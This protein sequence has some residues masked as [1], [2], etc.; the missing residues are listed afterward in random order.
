MWVDSIR[1]GDRE[2]LR[3]LAT[4]CQAA[5]EGNLANV[6][7][8]D[9]GELVQRLY[10]PLPPAWTWKKQDSRL[11][12]IQ[13]TTYGSEYVYQVDGW[14]NPVPAFGGLA[15]GYYFGVGNAAF[16][17]SPNDVDLCFGHSMGGA[18]AT[19]A[20]E[21]FRRS[22]RPG[23]FAASFGSPRVWADGNSAIEAHD[24]HVFFPLDPVPLQPYDGFGGHNWKLGNDNYMALAAGLELVVPQGASYIGAITAILYTYGASWHAIDNY[25]RYFG[26]TGPLPLVNGFEGVEGMPQFFE[27]QIKGL[28]REQACDNSFHVIPPTD[29]ADPEQ[30]ADDM[31]AFWRRVVCPRL[32]L[33]YQVLSYQT[34]RIASMIWKDEANHNLGSLFRYNGT[35]RYGG[36]NTDWGRRADD[37]MPS[38]IAIGFAK[39]AG[40]YFYPDLLNVVQGAKP[41][42]GNIAFGAIVREDITVTNNQLTAAAITSWTAVG[43]ELLRPEVGTRRYVQCVITNQNGGIY[44]GTAPNRRWQPIYITDPDDA[45]LPGFGVAQLNSLALNPLATTRNSRK[46]TQARRG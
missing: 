19:V 28:F 12:I 21:M 2:K 27:V 41:P 1:T 10:S 35:V 5:Y 43:T 25:I 22:T 7:G 4:C 17:A 34:R 8:P 26:G 14:L 29:P 15:N 44:V 9:A 31:R 42:K 38:M 20:A 37:S 46:Q 24:I 30:V 36:Q 32:S 11:M 13:G 33:G 16:N 39:V 40:N 3:Y 18:C 23:C 6:I 45:A